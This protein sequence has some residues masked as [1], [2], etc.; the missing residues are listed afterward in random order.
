MPN[1]INHPLHNGCKHHSRCHP[2]PFNNTAEDSEQSPQVSSTMTTRRRSSAYR[3]HSLTSSNMLAIFLVA[4][5]SQ[6]GMVSSFTPNISDNVVHAANASTQNESRQNN[7]SSKLFYR[8]RERWEEKTTPLF[9]GLSLNN[10]KVKNG[11]HIL[12][13]NSSG[14]AALEMASPNELYNKSDRFV[15]DEFENSSLSTAID[16]ASIPLLSRNA[17]VNVSKSRNALSGFISNV[18]SV[19]LPTISLNKQKITNDSTL[20]VNHSHEPNHQQRLDIARHQHVAP[21]SRCLCQ[22]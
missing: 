17:S 9:D 10:L 12:L 20:T 1:I 4:L 18:K 16:K 11:H 21:R 15:R 2:A 14:A 22:W 13:D 8:V 3:R 5:S 6:A 19:K 7:A